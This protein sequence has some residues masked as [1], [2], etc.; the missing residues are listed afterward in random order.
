MNRSETANVAIVTGA[1]RGL[2]RALTAALLERGWTVV[3]DARRTEELAATEVALDSPGLI[4]IA[5]DVTD[6]SHRVA[7]IEAATNAG[8]LRLLVNNA[9]RLAPAR[10]RSSPTTRLVTCGQCTR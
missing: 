3:V 6:A 2:G 5:G 1:S 8:P 10:S 7:L 9:S 4:A